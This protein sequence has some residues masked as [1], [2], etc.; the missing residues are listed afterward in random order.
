MIVQVLVSLVLTFQ[1]WVDDKKKT[2]NAN[3]NGTLTKRQ[4]NKNKRIF[5]TSKIANFISFRTVFFFF[6][7][8]FVLFMREHVHKKKK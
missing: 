1:S 6:L 3:N 7:Q 4:L 8:L 5:F 2:T